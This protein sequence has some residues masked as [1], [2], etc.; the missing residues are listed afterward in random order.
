MSA[1]P[2]CLFC[3][4]VAGDIPCDK[5]YED[6]DVLA[7]NDINPQAPVH[8]LVIP[9]CHIASLE[10]LT[11]DDAELIG[12]VQLV[13]QKIAR[14]RGVAENGYRTVYNCG[15]DGLQSVGH[16]HLHVLAGRRMEWP[17]G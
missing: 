11:E 7:F 14:E 16:L 6:D 5:L 9:K 2:D 1:D 17:P 3:K 4:I 13:A 10:D 15:A 8:F 12:K